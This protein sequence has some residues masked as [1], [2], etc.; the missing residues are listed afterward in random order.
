M[1]FRA[2]IDITGH[3][4]TDFE[5]DSQVEADEILKNMIAQTGGAEGVENR[6]FPWQN[7][8]FLITDKRVLE[9]E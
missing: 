7:Y 6:V 9:I 4:S 1:K 3:L 2:E 5:A 8:H